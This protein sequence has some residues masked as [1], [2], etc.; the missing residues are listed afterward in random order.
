MKGDKESVSPMEIQKHL[1]DVDY[2]ASRKDLID[3]A[4]SSGAD[5]KIIDTL[6]ELPARRYDS[7]ADVTKH[8]AK[9][10]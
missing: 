6:K 10:K 5:E 8:V 2:P 3:K 7:P 1:K 9:H 4:S